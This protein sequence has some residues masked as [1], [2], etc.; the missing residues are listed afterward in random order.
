[1]FNVFWCVDRMFLTLRYRLEKDEDNESRQIRCQVEKEMRPCFK[2][3]LWLG[4]GQCLL[5]TQTNRGENVQRS[6]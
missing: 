6:A 3:N 2:A 4:E 5:M 1:M